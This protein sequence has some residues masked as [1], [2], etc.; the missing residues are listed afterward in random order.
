MVKDT[1]ITLEE[2]E[3]KILENASNLIIEVM[4]TM[5][6]DCVI[7]NPIDDKTSF[8]TYDELNQLCNILESF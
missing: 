8:W 6:K 5:V 3:V 4:N 2:E 1:L 7:N